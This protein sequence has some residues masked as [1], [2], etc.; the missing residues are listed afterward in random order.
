MKKRILGVVIALVLC[1][2]LLPT[3]ALADGGPWGLSQGDTVSRQYDSLEEILE[4]ISASGGD[5]TIK[6]LDNYTETSS[7]SPYQ[8]NYT[9][10]LDLNGHALTLAKGFQLV[11]G[12]TLTLTDSSADAKGS[13]TVTGGQPCFTVDHSSAELNINSGICQSDAAVITAN[14]G[15]VRVTGGTL[16]GGRG[17]GSAAPRT[18]YSYGNTGITL[19]GSAVITNDC[20]ACVAL[21]GGSLKIQDNAS[22]KGCGGV[23]LFNSL[24][25]NSTDGNV[26]SSLTMT[27]GSVE[28]T[29]AG[30]FALT[31]NNLMSAGCSADITGGSL[32]AGDTSTA[33]YWPMEGALTIGGTASVTGG[34]GIEA[35]MG[36]IT[37]EDSATVTGTGTYDD[38]FKPV[39]GGSVTEG[40]ALLFST[41]MYG[42]SASQYGTSPNLTVHLNGGTLTS[43]NGNAVTIYNT[44]N[45]QSQTA[46]IYCE[47][48]VTL[49]G[50][51]QDTGGLFRFL[52]PTYKGLNFSLTPSQYG[53]AVSDKTSLHYGSGMAAAVCMNGHGI[54]YEECAIYPSV[55]EALE[56]AGKA[57]ADGG[58]SVIVSVCPSFGY[59]GGVIEL[60]EN[61]SKAVGLY[62]PE[63]LKN[64]TVRPSGGD[65]LVKET[66]SSGTVYSVAPASMKPQVGAPTVA[67]T[68]SG[69]SYVLSASLNLPQGATLDSFFC[70]WYKDGVCVDPQN[71]EFT[72]STKFTPTE[73]GTYTVE[74]WASFN[75]NNMTYLTPV[76]SKAAPAPG[77]GSTQATQTKQN[78]KTGV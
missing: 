9:C 40:S 41:Q 17:A 27:G 19:G 5:Y 63:N 6:L 67:V 12:G 16:A 64:L 24:K 78:P 18:I 54:Q 36:T 72:S 51:A 46:A 21:Y 44:D 60:P 55:A 14:S 58:S 38:D 4:A 10:T 74:V 57:A 39:N 8:I 2:G 47:D 49:S 53:G 56:A 20:D 1:L 45:T 26:H 50:G 73:P 75:W 77:T 30:D 76:A 35:K 31:G 66:N 52:A 33:I 25:N 61:L 3:T 62:V 11:N 22:L 68:Q 7:G 42:D 59:E 32:T 29:A 15:T 65:V 34:T 28:A 71:T 37:I 48:G 70:R 43:T 23:Y 69:G 13:F